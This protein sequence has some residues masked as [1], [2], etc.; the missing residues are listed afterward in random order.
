MLGLQY[1]DVFNG[2]VGNSDGDAARWHRKIEGWASGM[3]QADDNGESTRE[4][5]VWRWLWNLE[6]DSRWRRSSMLCRWL[7]FRQTPKC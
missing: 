2:Q 7:S 1:G 3:Q 4:T 6:I 5:V